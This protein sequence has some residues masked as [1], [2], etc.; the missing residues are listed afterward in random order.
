MHKYSEDNIKAYA[1]KYNKDENNAPVIVAAGNGY[2]AQKIIDI[3]NKCGICV[4]HDDS[5]ATLLSSLTLGSEVPEE[6]YKI[7]VDIYLTLMTAAEQS[8]NNL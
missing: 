1:L 3:A 7:V 5:T 2:V 6:L 8:K 4:Y